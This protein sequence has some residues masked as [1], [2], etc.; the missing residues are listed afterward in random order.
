M[1]LAGDSLPHTGR[2]P[3]P[4]A[5]RG[6]RRRALV[7]S[8]LLG[9]VL[10]ACS[11]ETGTEVVPDPADLIRVSAAADTVEVGQA[12]DPPMA[13]RVE[14]SLGEPVEGVPVRFLLA[15]GPGEVSPNLQ[16][17][18][19]QGVAEAEFRTG[20][21]T[22]ASRVRV[23]VPSATNVPSLRFELSTVPA[24][25]VRLEVVDG[26]DQEAEVG[27]Q[28]PLPFR[29]EAT[30]PSGTPTGGVTVAWALVE[31][32]DDARLASDTTFTDDEGRTGNLLTLGGRPVDHVVRAWALGEGL[33]TDTVEVEAAALAE[34]SGEVRLDSV[35][36]VPL[37][38]GGEAVLHGEGF[39]ARAENVEVRVEGLSGTVTGVGDGQVQ[40]RLPA[41]EGR[42]LP[43][44]EVGVRALV[45][46]QPSNG[47]LQQ[48]DA[49]HSSLDLAVGETRTLQGDAATRCLQIE[50]SE[51]PREYLL[52][53]GTA[54][55]A[56]GSRIPLRLLLRAETDTA[57]GA[58][59]ERREGRRRPGSLELDD[60]HRAEGELRTGAVRALNR[61]G[62]G[63]VVAGRRQRRD[64]RTDAG[65]GAPSV[66]DTTR[67]S[68]AV[69][70]GLSVSC[71]D[72]DRT[73]EGVTRAV[74]ESVLLVE[75]T[76]A[77]SGGFTDTDW[78]RLREEFDRVVLP[79]DSAY[80][81]GPADLD[82]NG[83][84]IVLFTP[85]VNQLSPRS[86]AA[87]LGGFFLPLDLVD[88]GDPEGD[89]LQGPEGQVCP[90]SNEGEVLYVAAPDPAG[91]FSRPLSRTT[92]L[93]LARTITSHEL[94]HLLSA[95]Q[96][97]VHDGGSFDRLGTAWLQEG[98]AH[99]AE[100]VVGLRLAELGVGR[101]LTWEETT[102]DRRR[103]ELF[104]TFHLNNFTRLNFFLLDPTAAPTLAPVD[105]G[106]L[107]GLQMRGFSWA[108]VRWLADRTGGDE[109][110]LFRRLSRGGAG[111]EQGVANVAQATGERWDRLLSDFLMALPVDDAGLEGDAADR[112]LAS[113][114]LPSIFEALARNPGTR[115]QFP[116]SAPLQPRRLPFGNASVG[117]ETAASSASYFQLR[118]SGDGQILALRL[119]SQNGG[120][121]PTTE[122][123]LIGVVRLR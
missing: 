65:D 50:A 26:A 62:L 77:P 29:L 97:L 63:R 76:A 123:P 108:F 6:R 83:R 13:V 38:A 57:S 91:R 22:G 35:S 33:V 106:G 56:A 75:D 44:R 84:V 85:R 87:R 93:R 119:A 70:D 80:F 69:D 46:G 82:G 45:R 96:R 81:G 114:H 17:S 102:G 88:S 105:P 116:R 41:F 78:A 28:L 72:T 7:G 39:G 53:A 43:N 117:F 49:G 98:L 109:R 86:S 89:G 111:H 31:S 12:T 66:G 14:N 110:Q 16:V 92:G 79:T 30:T 47:L 74:G 94:E 67:F 113:W 71:E 104:N 55:Q 1:S 90:A 118:D 120:S 40:F 115:S 25:E 4:T 3:A 2:G 95:Q 52:A 32:P 60:R 107:E 64:V 73:V 59:E 11:G 10:V 15:S 19:E 112:G 9:A 24:G 37:Q 68:F 61:A 18:N 34:L 5:R 99:L 101:N 54:S 121:V 23:D 20:S 122:A 42:C 100:E 48:M 58:A 36:P 27:S 103:L 21:E 8:V 51:E